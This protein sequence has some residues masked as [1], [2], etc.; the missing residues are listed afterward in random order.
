VAADQGQSGVVGVVQALAA[1][2]PVEPA[3]LRGRLLPAAAAALL[4]GEVLL[5]CRELPGSCGEVARV[6]DVRSVAGGQEGR[7]AH[8]DADCGTDWLQWLGG[9]VVAGQDH[10]P[11]AV[12]ALGG[13]GLDAALDRPVLVDANVADALE[14]DTGDRGMR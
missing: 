6:G 2:L 3:D 11:A 8:V 5:S 4:A 1:H 7:H 9:H 13:D 12:L 14:V 10:V